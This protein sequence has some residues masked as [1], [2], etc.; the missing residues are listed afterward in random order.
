M[1]GALKAQSN[2]P[3][4]KHLDKA[5]LNQVNCTPTKQQT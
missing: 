3:G 4:L 1:L 2:T 5:N